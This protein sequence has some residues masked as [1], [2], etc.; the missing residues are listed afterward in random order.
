MMVRCMIL[1]NYCSERS[2]ELPYQD[3]I[4]PLTYQKQDHCMLEAP[5]ECKNEWSKKMLKPSR[6]T[7]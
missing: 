5:P 1:V 7:Y 3:F 2:P 4:Y 6:K